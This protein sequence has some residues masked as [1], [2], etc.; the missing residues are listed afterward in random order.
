[1]ISQQ[2]IGSARLDQTVESFFAMCPSAARVWDL[3]DEAIPEPATIG[4]WGHTVVEVVFQDTLPQSRV[5]RI[6]V[7]DSTAHF[8]GGV[9]PGAS[10]NAFEVAFGRVT[11]EERECALHAGFQ[12]TRGIEVWLGVSREIDCTQTVAL[13]D[14][15]V[16]GKLRTGVRAGRVT[17]FAPG[18]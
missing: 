18:P 14:S 5:S 3:G 12:R 16:T 7:E 4:L 2:G 9:A 13:A 11:I 10:L 6:M 8:A 1:V 17:I 15:I